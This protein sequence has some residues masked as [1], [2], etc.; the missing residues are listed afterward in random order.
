MNKKVLAI[1]LGLMLVLGAAV[2]AAELK[3]EDG[4]LCENVKDLEPVNPGTVFPAD[5]GKVCCFT[6][7]V[8]A[9][10][11]TTVSHVWYLNGEQ[12]ADVELKVGSANWRTYSSKNIDRMWRGDGMVE[13]KDADGNVIETLEFK[14]VSPDKKK[15]PGH[16]G[17]GPE[18]G[19]EEGKP[20]P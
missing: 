19:E 10:E 1:G 5:I 14:I 13:V 3:V 7:I 12:I 11:E 15:G 16:K 6:R 8:G 20:M 9:E 2:I 17:S 18:Q 4:V